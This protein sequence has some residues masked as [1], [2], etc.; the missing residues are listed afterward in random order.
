VEICSKLLGND[1]FI[2][3]ENVKLDKE[4]E[5]VIRKL[6]MIDSCS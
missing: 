2:C 4:R 5:R 6:L 1:I 3:Y